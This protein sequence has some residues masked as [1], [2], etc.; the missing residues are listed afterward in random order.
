MITGTFIDEISHDIPSA[1]WGAEQWAQDFR[2][3]R[4]TGI[5]TVIL[6]RCGYQNKCTFYS[7]V[8][9]KEHPVLLVQDDLIELFLTLCD[10]LDLKFFWGTY[11]SG[12]YWHTGHYQREVDLNRAIAD[13]VW[14]RYGAH[15]SFAG[16]YLC[17]E[18]NTFDEGVMQVY[19]QLA[20]HLKG[21]QN[22]PLLISPYVR[23]IK[24]FQ[25]AITLTDHERQWEQ[26]FSRIQGLVDCVA[27]QDG[28]VDFAELPDYLAVN[29]ALARRHG[30]QVWSNVES[31]DR[32]M[33]IKFPP[34]SWPKLRFKI[35]AAQR[36]GVDK[37]ITF[38]FSHFMSPNAIYP[39]AHNL[40]QRYQEWRLAQIQRISN[41]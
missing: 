23:G 6:I 37:L 19:E 38:E 2:A 18:I 36:A 31:F 15:P 30:I 41:P 21:L 16:W 28:Q 17:H 1:N 11:D 34:I 22:L 13:E 3:M 12:L 10:Q 5:D 7:K 9:A 40:H 14:T 24:Q 35:E 25:E 32:D 20:Q 4:A 8:L 27:F 29:A 26:V 39:A 33:P